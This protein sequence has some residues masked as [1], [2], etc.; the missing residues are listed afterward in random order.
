[1]TPKSRSHSS[2]HATGEGAGGTHQPFG[3]KVVGHLDEDVVAEASQTRQGKRN[4][5]SPARGHPHRFRVITLSPLEEASVGTALSQ[6]NWTTKTMSEPI[7][8]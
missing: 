1:M 3:K 5:E 7:V 6:K 8:R 4:R 2:I